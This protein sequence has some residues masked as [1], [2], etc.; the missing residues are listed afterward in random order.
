MGGIFGHSAGLTHQEV[1]HLTMV[2]QHLTPVT[3]A[4]GEDRLAKASHIAL[5]I[6][7]ANGF[8]GFHIVFACHALHPL[9]THFASAAEEQV[10]SGAKNCRYS[11]R[12][13]TLWIPTRD[14]SSVHHLP[15]DL[16]AFHVPP[17]SGALHGDALSGLLLAA[18]KGDDVGLPPRGGA[19]AAVRIRTLEAA[20]LPG[21]SR[22]T[23]PAEAVQA[24][25]EVGILQ[26]AATLDAGHRRLPLGRG[27]RRRRGRLR[28]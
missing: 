24:G 25:Q 28:L 27:G 6:P 8:I 7:R 23:L 11:P 13:F 4:A 3:R 21:R 22:K 12:I 16:L 26:V 18:G 19:V 20:I 17:D 15:Q 2:F 14:P 1:A 9:V 10:T 5:S